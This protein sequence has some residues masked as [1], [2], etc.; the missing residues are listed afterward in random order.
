MIY[1]P[2]IHPSFLNVYTIPGTFFL[3]ILHLCTA[4]KF[5]KFKWGSRRS[6]L[7]SRAADH[8]KR[9]SSSHL[10]TFTEVLPAFREAAVCK[11][12][13]SS[14]C[15]KS[16]FTTSTLKLEMSASSFLVTAMRRGCMRT[17]RRPF[18]MVSFHHC[19]QLKYFYYFSICERLISLLSLLPYSHFEEY[20]KVLR[21]FRETY[22]VPV[23]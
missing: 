10:V 6:G 21:H 5:L 15:V 20:L 3:L 16:R 23:F 4:D 2:L 11:V 17:L 1:K 9:P 22:I 13:D 19:T 12:W 14:S 8:L 18:P 7:S